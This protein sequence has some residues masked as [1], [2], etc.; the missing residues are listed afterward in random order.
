MF[1]RISTV[2]SVILMGALLAIG[3]PPSAFAGTKEEEQARFSQ[4]LKNG[5]AKLGTGSDTRVQVTLRDKTKLE[6]SIVQ[7]GDTSF[8]VM[9]HQTGMPTTVA[10]G[11]VA[12]V[13]GNNLSTGAQI[14]ITAGIAIGGTLLLLFLLAAVFND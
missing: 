2:C 1:V 6:G 7:V 10:Y 11:N 5:I 8:V 14:A 3:A 4:K 12:K 13:K 9:D